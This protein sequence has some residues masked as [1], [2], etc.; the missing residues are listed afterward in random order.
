M[1]IGLIGYGAWG[2]HH[3]DAIVETPGLELVRICAQSEESRAAARQ[4]LGV[5][6]TA[7]YRE[8]LATPGLEAVDIVLPTDMHHEVAGASLR[9]G[10]HVLLEKPMA[11]TTEQ[12]EDLIAVARQADRTLYVAHEF[13]LS[14][15]WGRMRNL[16]AEGVVGEVQAVTVDLFRFP[17]RLGSQGWRHN[18]KRVGSWVLEEPI[19]FFDLVCWWLREAGAPVTV[20]ARASRLPSTA[21]GLWDNIAAVLDFPTGAHATL[22]QNLAIAEH[23]LIAKVAGTKGA[24]IARWDGEADRTTKPSATLQLF[25]GREMK[26]L[27]IESSGEFFELRS[28]LAHIVDVCRKQAKPVISAEEAALAV[29]VSWA[30]EH[31][32]R[33]G[34]P[35]HI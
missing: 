35:E 16:I 24:L 21:D 14:T 10:K 5:P 6:V 34:Q 2:S 8:L 12:C 32:I 3:A 17:Y 4:K 7:D 31:S 25:D 29:K 1:K 20:Y 26:H 28:E 18:A 22:T 19:H 11:L 23:H 30:A 15:Q 13:R 27:P 9:A 33:S